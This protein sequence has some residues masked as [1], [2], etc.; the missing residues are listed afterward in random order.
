MEPL[1]RTPQN[2]A[3]CLLGLWC[4]HQAEHHVTLCFCVQGSGLLVSLLPWLSTPNTE[5]AAGSK[6]GATV[7]NPYNSGTEW[8]DAQE[9]DTENQPGLHGKFQLSLSLSVRLSQTNNKTKWKEWL[10]LFPTGLELNQGWDSGTQLYTVTIQ[11]FQIFDSKTLF[12]DI[13]Q[14]SC[15]VI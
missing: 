1:W 4:L 13:L 2:P 3:C 8:T 12:D 10:I 5:W 7:S 11:S 9:L 14:I 15:T 6:Y